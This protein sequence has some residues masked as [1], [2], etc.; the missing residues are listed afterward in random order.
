MTTNL[1][2]PVLSAFIFSLVGSA[3]LHALATTAGPAT[4]VPSYQVGD[5]WT[6]RAQD[7]FL[8]KQRWVETHEGMVDDPT[9]IKVRITKKGVGIFNSHME[10]WTGQGQGQD[11]AMSNAE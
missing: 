10:D 11:G 8:A 6:Y 2:K 1:S 3:S 4:P 9:G 7:G 5:R